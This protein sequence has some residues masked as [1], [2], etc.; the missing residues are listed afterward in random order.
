VRIETKPIKEIIEDPENAR[1]HGAR[2][3]EAIEKSLAAFGQQKPI[4]IN[5]EGKVIAG[6]G[7]LQA[8]Q[9]IGWETIQVVKT[10]LPELQ[11][12]AFAVADN[13]TAEM[14]TWD[15]EVL[16]R[17]IKEVAE[18]DEILAVQLG[19]EQDEIKRMLERL[20]IPEELDAPDWANTENQE[21][22]NTVQRVM[23]QFTLEEFK[24]FEHCI[25]LLKE[26]HG[27]SDTTSAV[28]AAVEQVTG[29]EIK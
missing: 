16:A 27:V 2:N 28:I 6:N 11:Q 8:A 10:E 15:E 29:H 25:S 21:V 9:A 23:M 4:V 18:I 3:L 20:E 24:A 22:D 19:F 5:K 1:E 14:A 7:T 12:K 17:T 13:R 26:T